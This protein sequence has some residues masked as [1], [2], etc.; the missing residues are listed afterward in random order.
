MKSLIFVFG[1]IGVGFLLACGDRGEVKAGLDGVE[2]Y[3]WEKRVILSFVV[4]DGDWVEQEKLLGRL[5]DGVEDRDLVVLRVGE[6][7]G[8]VEKFG[9]RVGE[10]VLLGKDGGV[11]G[12]QFGSLDLEKWFGLIDGMPMR[13]RE[14]GE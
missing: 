10:Y 12:R 9:M 11:K 4:N 13:K 5:K 3:R 7:D 8:V 14:M 1:A 2:K 6:G